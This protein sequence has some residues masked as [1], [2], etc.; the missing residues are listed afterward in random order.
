MFRVGLG[1][2][3]FGCRIWAFGLGVEGLVLVLR[4]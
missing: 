1:L 2:R 3:G 4:V